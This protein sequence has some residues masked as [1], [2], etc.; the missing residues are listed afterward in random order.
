M[1]DL[2]ACNDPATPLDGPRRGQ[3]DEAREAEGAFVSFKPGACRA[4][5]TVCELIGRRLPGQAA[6][7]AARRDGFPSGASPSARRRPGGSLA[8]ALYRETRP[9]DAAPGGCLDKASTK[10]MTAY[11]TRMIACR[12]RSVVLGTAAGIETPGGHL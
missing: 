5:S 10:F 9:V 8:T 12:L 11:C 2:H 3:A 1:S 6:R 4:V 7:R